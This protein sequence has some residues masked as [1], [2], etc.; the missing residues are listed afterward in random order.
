MND[1][2]LDLPISMGKIIWSFILLKVNKEV[3]KL[4]FGWMDS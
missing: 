1:D 3:E 2:K 4:E